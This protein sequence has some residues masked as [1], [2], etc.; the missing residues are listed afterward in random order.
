MKIKPQIFPI[1]TSLCCATSFV[2][3]YV[4]NVILDKSEAWISKISD[5]GGVMPASGVFAIFLNLGVFNWLLTGFFV[6]ISLS[7]HIKKHSNHNSKL[8]YVLYYMVFLCITS[9]I[10]L[11]LVAAFPITLLRKVHGLA[12]T[13]AF[14]NGCLYLWVNVLFLMFY[15]PRL[16]AFW[17][18]VGQLV[19]VVFTSFCVF[20]HVLL[21]NSK[22]FVSEV[23]GTRPDKPQYKIDQLVRLR[24]GDPYYMNNMIGSI[25][26]WLL[27]LGFCLITASFAL[28]LPTYELALILRVKKA[29]IC[30][31][32]IE[33][34]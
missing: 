14:L 23:N 4:I 24:P 34:E 26:E 32:H 20:T 29:Y 3:G 12:A 31:V 8:H 13:V 6:H 18:S 28:Q 5:G 2:S 27:A 7:Q 11:L 9:A 30:K 15:R 16:I 17:I 33:K 22:L 21:G 25:T 10:G 1:A 19:G